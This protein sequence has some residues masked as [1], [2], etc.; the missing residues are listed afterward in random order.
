MPCPSPKLQDLCS[1]VLQG[2]D[3]G[4]YRDTTVTCFVTRI[5]DSGPER[6]RE[7]IFVTSSHA[8][9]GQSATLGYM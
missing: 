8:I 1:N 7:E 6:I 5:M 4:P 3:E 9:Q 2:F